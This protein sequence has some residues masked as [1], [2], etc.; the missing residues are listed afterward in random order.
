MYAHVH[1]HKSFQNVYKNIFKYMYLK[2]DRK[3]LKPKMIFISLF[4]EC[5]FKTTEGEN[6]ILLKKHVLDI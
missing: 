1:V 6:C 4:N 2:I 3:I 5:P